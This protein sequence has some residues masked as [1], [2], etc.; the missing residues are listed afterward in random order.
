MTVKSKLKKRNKEKKN[1]S[2]RDKAEKKKKKKKRKCYFYHKEGHYI[3][4]CFEKKKL[5][6]IHKEL[7]GKVVVAFEDER[8]SEGAY[9]LVRKC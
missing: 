3:K 4:E 8:D 5:E 1:N 6:K 2:Q 7:T 9:V